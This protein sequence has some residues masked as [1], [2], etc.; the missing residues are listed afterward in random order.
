MNAVELSYSTANIRQLAHELDI[1]PELTYR[2][3]SEFENYH[4]AC[5][6]GNV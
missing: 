3:R 4:G 2:W 1:P 6:P 5:L